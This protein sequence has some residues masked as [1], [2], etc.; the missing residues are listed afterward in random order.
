MKKLPFILYSS[1]SYS[2]MKGQAEN[3]VVRI[4]TDGGEF[5]TSTNMAEE[6]N[7]GYYCIELTDEE[8]ECQQFAVVEISCPGAQTRAFSYTTDV[9][10]NVWDYKE[11]TLTSKIPEYIDP[12]EDVEPDVEEYIYPNL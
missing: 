1:S 3:I 2:P 8:L 12:D 11:R 4:S 5:A 9:A 6:F 10:E 7:S